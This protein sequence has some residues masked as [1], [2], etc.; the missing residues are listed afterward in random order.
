MKVIFTVLLIAF[1]SF[2]LFAQTTLTKEEY[3]V[4]AAVMN[5]IYARNTKHNEIYAKNSKDNEIETSFVIFEN[6][7]EPNLETLEHNIKNQRILDYLDITVPP[8]SS[9]TFVFDDLLKNLEENNEN[10]AKLDGRIPIDYKY[11]FISK[12]ELDNLLKEGK[13]EY[14]E[15][16]KRCN[17]VFIGA[18][19]IWQPFFRKY[20]SYQG[21]Y[22]F[23]KVGFSSDKQFALVFFKTE[24][25]DHGSSTFYVL[26]KTN[27]KWEVMKALGSYRIS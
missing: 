13:K 1:S 6:T 15:E 20:R 3:G 24:S 10:S 2:N 26:E 21:Y 16:L 27:D 14:E 5:E 8:N 25:G 19:S 7:V 23:S 12:D 22:S 18:G 17:C 4:Y 9:K 11:S